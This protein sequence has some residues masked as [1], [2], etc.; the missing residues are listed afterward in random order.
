MS[1]DELNAS[2]LAELAALDRIL[3][4]EPVDEEHL[5]LAALVDSVRAGAP[6]MGSDFAAQLD[7]Q[8]ASALERSAARRMRVPRLG[9]RRLAFAGGGVVAAAV[10]LTIVISGGLLDGA[11][12]PPA[13]STPRGQ[14][15]AFEPAL[16]RATSHGSAI[17][18]L[19]PAGGASNVPSSVA[20]PTGATTAAG[21]AVTGP[22]GAALAPN[23]GATSGT[24]SGPRLVHRDSTLTLASSPATMQAVANQIVSATEQQGGVVENSDVNVQGQASYASFSLQ[25]PSGHLAPLIATLSS[26]ASVRALTQSTTDITDGYNVESARLADSVAERAA[27]LKKLATAATTADATSYQRQIDALGHRIAA[28][29]RAIDRLLNQGHTATLQVNVVPGPST[30]HA[31]VAGPL[32]SAFHKALHALQEILAIALIVLAIVLPF[33]LTALALWWSAASLRQRARERAMKA[34]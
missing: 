13:R 10:A 18:P 9:L 17:A 24:T 34:A 22:F 26:L 12:S 30:K 27:L 19:A 32:A 28:Q 1:R 16:K 5:E 21:V 14:G 20:A 7:S 11:A 2:Q 25:V 33:A 31:V 29:H 8:I 15:Q 23:R 6:R 4:R 3:A